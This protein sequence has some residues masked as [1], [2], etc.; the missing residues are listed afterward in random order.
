MRDSFK[1]VLEGSHIVHADVEERISFD[2]KCYESW[3]NFRTSLPLDKPDILFIDNDISGNGGFALLED[4]QR[5]KEHICSI[6]TASSVTME[7]AIRTLML[8][9][10]DFLAKPVSPVKLRFH[11]YKAARYIILTR[12]AQQL[13]QEKKRVRF[14]VVSVLAHEMKS[15]LNAVE[16]YSYIIANRLSG[17]N[18]EDYNTIVERILVRIHGMQKLIT[19]LLDLTSLELVERQR[20]LVKVDVAAI[21]HETADSLKEE[22]VAG[23]IAIELQAENPVMF[24]VDPGDMEMVLRNL[25]SNAIKYNRQDGRVI[26]GIKPD[27][28]GIIIEVSDT[29]I[30]MNKEDQTLLFKEFSR[31]KNEKTRNIMGSGLG[32]SIVKKIALIYNGDITIESESGKGTTLR[33]K[34][35]NKE[36]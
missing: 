11:V 28:E 16:S 5:K 17:N 25:I 24:E 23:N 30:G 27:D 22:T 26:V 18:I 2:V 1:W 20:N 36:P 14:E 19:D 13:A 29:G 33:V 6:M 31:I 34:L 35:R 10:Y 12:R 8:G 7:R 4:L 9:G 32:L 21:A 15:P 3:E